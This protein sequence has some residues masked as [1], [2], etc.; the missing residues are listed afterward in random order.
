MTTNYPQNVPLKCA[1]GVISVNFFPRGFV[2]AS[3]QTGKIWQMADGVKAVSRFQYDVLAGSW[4]H[5]ETSV[6]RVRRDPGHGWWVNPPT[7]KYMVQL[8][9]S[10]FLKWVARENNV[11][12]DIKGMWVAERL[13][14][15]R[16]QKEDLLN[17]ISQIENEFSLLTG[18]KQCG[19]N[20]SR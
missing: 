3:I 20:A 11:I 14:D 19:Y 5:L 12:T 16:Q 6:T 15:L 17:K 1:R 18:K 8:M 13:E 4:E 2:T 10:S 9:G 7:T